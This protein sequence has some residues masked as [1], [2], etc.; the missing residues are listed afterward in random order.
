MKRFTFKLT[1]A[2]FVLTIL[3]LG[4]EQRP[5]KLTGVEFVAQWGGE[6]SE[7]GK[8]KEPIG[9]ALDGEGHL[10]VADAGNN[11][12]QKFTTDGKFLLTWGMQGSA[13]GELDRPIH[14]SV[15]SDS[16]V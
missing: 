5:K 15:S 7:P 8:L 10:Y 2:L 11:R 6:G 14:L 12:I 13:E 9:L 1:G 4:C 16:L 3:F